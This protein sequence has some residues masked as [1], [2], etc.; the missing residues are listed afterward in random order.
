MLLLRIEILLTTTVKRFVLNFYFQASDNVVRL[1]PCM[2]LSRNDS[3]AI[4]TIV[5]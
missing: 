2:A 4:V 5:T 1:S 3:Y